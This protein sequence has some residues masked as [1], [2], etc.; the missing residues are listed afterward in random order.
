[1]PDDFI[2]PLNNVSYDAS[3][4]QADLQNRNYD[5]SQQSL[6]IQQGAVNRSQTLAPQYNDLANQSSAIDTDQ[7]QMQRDYFNPIYFDL[8]NQSYDLQQQ[9]NALTHQGFD[10]SRQALQAQ[11]AEGYRGLAGNAAASGSTNAGW[12]HNWQVFLNDWL[13]QWTGQGLTEQR[14]GLSEQQQGIDKYRSDLGYNQQQYGLTG[15]LKHQGLNDQG[16]ALDY[17]EQMAR[18]GDQNSELGVQGQRIGLGREGVATGLS[19]THEYLANQDQG[20]QQDLATQ[21]F[22]S[23]G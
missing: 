2:N 14:Q 21:A 16:R 19:D 7:L 4:H 23:G 5:L 10:L 6:G 18:Y 13:R 8:N 3:Q 11:K 1:M 22:L 17:N 9:G 12:G 15:Q 20:Y